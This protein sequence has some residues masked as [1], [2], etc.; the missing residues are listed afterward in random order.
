MIYI[1]NVK[2]SFFSPSA[3]IPMFRTVVSHFP[4]SKDTCATQNRIP[5]RSISLHNEVPS[6]LANGDFEQTFARDVSRLLYILIVICRWEWYVSSTKSAARIL[7]RLIQSII[8]HLL[9]FYFLAGFFAMAS[10][11]PLCDRVGLGNWRFSVT[12]DLPYIRLRS[13]TDTATIAISKGERPFFFSSLILVGDSFGTEREGGKDGEELRSRRQSL[14][15]PNG[16]LFAEG[17]L[18]VST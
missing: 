15:L 17:T 14:Q 7:T 3:P 10:I 16:E 5:L 13:Y 2:I 4:N 1:F 9:L 8:F 6:K 18:I 12:N 11:A